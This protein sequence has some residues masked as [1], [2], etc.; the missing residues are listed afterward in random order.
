M[1]GLE[2]GTN[3]LHGGAWVFTSVRR[4]GINDRAYGGISNAPKFEKLCNPGRARYGRTFSINETVEKE[5]MALLSSSK[6]VYCAFL[7]YEKLIC[8]AQSFERDPICRR[9]MAVSLKTYE[10]KPGEVHWFSGTEV[11]RGQSF[12]SN[13]DRPTNL[14]PVDATRLNPYKLERRH[15]VEAAL[16]SAKYRTDMNGIIKFKEQRNIVLTYLERPDQKII[17]AANS[18][19]NWPEKYRKMVDIPAAAGVTIQFVQG[20]MYF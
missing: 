12:L 15:P 17:R 19:R 11:P 5:Y 9:E 6:S 2:G 10:R 1:S 18:L 7:M 13:V 20:T 4:R 8:Y 3:Q 14:S 16:E